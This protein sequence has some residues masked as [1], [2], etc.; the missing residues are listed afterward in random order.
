MTSKSR[1][2]LDL[3]FR[4]CRLIG[5]SS[6]LC[7]DKNSDTTS[8]APRTGVV[9]HSSK[10]ITKGCSWSLALPATPRLVAS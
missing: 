1:I 6:L 10:A 7:V 9:E 4:T 5:T 8:F 3:P 2:L